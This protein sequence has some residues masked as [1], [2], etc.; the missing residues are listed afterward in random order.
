MPLQFIDIRDSNVKFVNEDND[1]IN[2]LET[3]L[4]NMVFDSMQDK[5]KISQLE[6]ELGVALLEIMQLKLGGN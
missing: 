3:D 6:N 4:A 1:P 5:L 2:A